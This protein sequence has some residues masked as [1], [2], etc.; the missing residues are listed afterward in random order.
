[1][2]TGFTLNLSQE[3]MK[4]ALEHY[5]KT[6]M[7]KDPDIIVESVKKTRKADNSFEV[8]V[9]PLGESDLPGIRTP[10]GAM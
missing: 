7:L 6:V 8:I 2:K 9:N 10:A 1:M 4:A 5:L 3:T